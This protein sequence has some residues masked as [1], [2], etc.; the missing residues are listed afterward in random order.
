LQT[1]IGYRY[2]LLALPAPGLTRLHCYIV[3]IALSF[4]TKKK[5]KRRMMRKKRRREENK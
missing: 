1:S 4:I 3:N 2:L 5:S